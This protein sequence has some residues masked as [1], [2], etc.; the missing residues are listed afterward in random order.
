MSQRQ[1]VKL[2]VIGCTGRRLAIVLVVILTQ[3]AFV[4]KFAQNRGA[5][6]TPQNQP[7]FVVDAE[8][9][10]KMVMQPSSNSTDVLVPEPELPKRASDEYSLQRMRDEMEEEDNEFVNQVRLLS[11]WRLP[12]IKLYYSIL[13]CIELTSDL[14][15]KS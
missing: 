9:K 15:K 1:C 2:S 7:P 8:S 5:G 10:V 11:F 12:Q 3:L 14:F 4:A 13:R 6:D